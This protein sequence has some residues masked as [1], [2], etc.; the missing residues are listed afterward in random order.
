MVKFSL[1]ITINSYTLIIYKTIYGDV[2]TVP[3]NKNLSVVSVAMSKKTQF[4]MC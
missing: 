3:I 1:M 2:S 4:S